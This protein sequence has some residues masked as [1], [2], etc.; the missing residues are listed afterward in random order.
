MCHAEQVPLGL[1]GREQ[2]SLI[3]AVRVVGRAGMRGT[4]PVS[5]SADSV[6]EL[7]FGPWLGPVVVGRVRKNSRCYP[8]RCEDKDVDGQRCVVGCISG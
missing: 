5:S 8:P 7:H 4:G 6:R 2:G 3:D 1:D